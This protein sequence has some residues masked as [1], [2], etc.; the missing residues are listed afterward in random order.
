[1]AAP[2]AG[3]THP[4]DPHHPDQ[5]EAEAILPL[6]LDLLRGDVAGAFPTPDLHLQL[7]VEAGQTLH[8][9]VVVTPSGHPR[10][11]NFLSVDGTV[12]AFHSLGLQHPL[13]TA[14]ADAV[15]PDLCPVLLLPLVAQLDDATPH[16]PVLRA[17]SIE[18]EACPRRAPAPHRVP[19][20]TLEEAAI[21]IDR[22]LVLPPALHFR[23]EDVEHRFLPRDL[24]RLPHVP[25]DNAAAPV[26][27]T[28]VVHG[29]RQAL[30]RLGVLE[31][32]TSCEGT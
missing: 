5:A 14:I 9:V 21:E 20:T 7:D 3:R 4:H 23:L 8:H 26:A 11:T 6:F 10:A 18:A 24:R 15:T 17:A 16:L 25:V 12:E 28:D 29:P 1:M 2:E 22:Y 27:R 13:A 31:R 19:D 32:R 30:T